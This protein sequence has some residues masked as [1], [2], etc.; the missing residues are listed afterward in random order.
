MDYRLWPSDK[1]RCNAFWRNAPTVRFISNGKDYEENPE[2]KF[3][4]TVFGAV[5]EF[6]RAKIIERMMR[7]KMH[8]LR[9]GQ[10]PSQGHIV[11]GYTYIKKTDTAPRALVV[12]KEQ[13][14]VVRSIFEMYASG[15]FSTAAISRVLEERG[16]PTYS[17]GRLWDH[18]RIVRILKNHGYT[19]TRYF[20]RITVVRDV[21]ADGTRSATKRPKL[22]YRD[23]DEWIAVKVP[24]IVSRE[25]FDQVQERLQVAAARYRALPI[26]SFLSGFVRC[27]ICG[28]LYGSGY[29]YEKFRRRTGGI[30]VLQRGQYR[31]TRRFEDRM[32]GASNRGRCRNVCVATTILDHTVVGLIRAVMLDPTKLARC[33]E[34]GTAITGART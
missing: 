30:S 1:P 10:L 11:Y 22:V 8:R 34:G 7:G 18:T 27:A 9:M 33:I 6:E 31:C 2:N 14:A 32:H 4:L 21:S 25:L 29:P 23:R 12:N 17:G 3:A 15:E 20:N 24:A 13:S 5:A 26:Q 28:R 19:G 16:V